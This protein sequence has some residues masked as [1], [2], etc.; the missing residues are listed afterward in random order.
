M[1]TTPRIIH[2]MAVMAAVV[3]L[4][5]C[6]AQQLYGSGQGWQKNECN[7]LMDANERARCFK[8][9]DTD[10]ETY[11]RRAKDAKAGSQP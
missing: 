3:A 8:S 1:H 2:W 7:K 9:A 4:S 11:Q 5:A 10:Y 6:S